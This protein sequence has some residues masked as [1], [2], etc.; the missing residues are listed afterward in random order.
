MFK[1]SITLFLSLLEFTFVFRDYGFPLRLLN[2]LFMMF[3]TFTDFFDLS[4]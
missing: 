2:H 4:V 3:M 1:R